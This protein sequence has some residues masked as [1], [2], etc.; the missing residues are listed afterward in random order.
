MKNDIFT[1]AHTVEIV[2]PIIERYSCGWFDGGC[3]I[4]ARALQLWLGGRLAVLVRQELLDEQVFDHVLLSVDNT[5]DSL[6][7]DAD[8]VA[9]RSDLLQRWRN[10][11]RLADICLE[12]PADA[13]RFVG[14]LH[15]ESLS[16]W[17][18]EQL[19]NRFGLPDKSWLR[20]QLRDNVMSQ[21]SG[22]PD[23]IAGF[24]AGKY[25]RSIR[26]ATKKEYAHKYLVYI[27]NGRNGSSPERG[28]LSTMAAQAVRMRLDGIFQ[29]DSPCS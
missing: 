23:T 17:L 24:N 6:Y 25:I 9:T 8:G 4:F 15:K 20:S 16:R 1:F 7:I 5:D 29:A 3:F 11:E 12:D 19:R 10:R 26:S 22:G 2:T 27:L 28:V 13:I 14:H 21:I 18:S